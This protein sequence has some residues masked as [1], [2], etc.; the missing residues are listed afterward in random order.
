VKNKICCKD[1]FEK[2]SLKIKTT[3]KIKDSEKRSCDLVRV[4]ILFPQDRKVVCRNNVK[5][6]V[7][8]FIYQ[9]TEKN[10]NL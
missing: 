8:C 2:E 9:C 3:F 7:R 4:R 1:V 5:I 10:I 6:F